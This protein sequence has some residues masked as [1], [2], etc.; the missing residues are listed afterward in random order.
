[1]I[2]NADMPSEEPVDDALRDQLAQSDA[3]LESAVPILRHLVADE[4]SGAFADE[5]VARVRGGISD[6]AAQM[7][8]AVAATPDRT[9]TDPDTFD[10]LCKALLQ[11]P[12][13][14]GHLH[15]LAL[16]WQLTE[17]LQ[18]RLAL[19]PA[20]PPLLQALLAS[21]DAVTAE[22]AMHL[23]AA[24][25]RFAQAQRR[26]QFALHELPADL[27]HGSLI[28]M[29]AIVGDDNRTA[30]AEGALRAGYDESRTR[31]ALAARLVTGMGGGAVAALAVAH[32]G[33]ALFATALAIASGQDR[34]IVLLSI[35]GTSAARIALALKAAGLKHEA[36]EAQIVLLFT[37]APVAA[38]WDRVGPDRAA[39]LLGGMPFGSGGRT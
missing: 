4:H 15:A 12:G 9:A 26:M 28:A 23:L 24:Q 6:L 39:E 19:D 18:A 33:I 22:L 10:E 29:R 14:L 30:E 34:D 32:A 36:I 27:L 21:E 11:L 25:A 7:L 20:L 31:I 13:L 37:E 16:E 1:M 8:A 2:Q 5:I 3:F 35:G 38:E 17:R